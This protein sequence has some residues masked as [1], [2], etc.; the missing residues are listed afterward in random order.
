MDHQQVLSEKY[1]FKHP[2][3]EKYCWSPRLSARAGK[4][5][6][7]VNGGTGINPGGKKNSALT[8]GPAKV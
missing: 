6:N 7:G 3:D 1:G 4:T 2:Q 5:N 8:E